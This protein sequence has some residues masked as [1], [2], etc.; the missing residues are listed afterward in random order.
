MVVV[1]VASRTTSLPTSS[2]AYRRSRSTVIRLLRTPVATAVLLVL[3]RSEDF[4]RK[5]L[6]STPKKK[7]STAGPPMPATEGAAVRSTAP[8]VHVPTA[9]PCDQVGVA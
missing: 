9:N 3:V 2:A 7:W 8:P 6:S 5:K 4:T 1:A